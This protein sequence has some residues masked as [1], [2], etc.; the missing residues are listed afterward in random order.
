MTAECVQDCEYRP[1]KAPFKTKWRRR[2]GIEPA[3]GAGRR[4]MVLK[5][6]RAT[7]HPHASAREPTQ[8]LVT[9]RHRTARSTAVQAVVVSRYRPAARGTYATT[10]I[11]P[12]G[13]SRAI[14]PAGPAVPVET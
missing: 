14:A 12:N 3:V 9:S 5:T 7:R 1:T 8:L 13:S 6:R 10:R 4:P 11:V 2:T